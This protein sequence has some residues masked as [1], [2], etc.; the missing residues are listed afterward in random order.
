MIKPSFA[1]SDAMPTALQERA[2][3]L[4]VLMVIAPVAGTNDPPVWGKRQIESLGR[5][6]VEIAVYAF[7]NRRSLRGLLHGGRELRRKADEFQPHLIHVHFGAAQALMAVLFS[8][9]P[10]IVSF[11]GSDLLGNY[12]ASGRKTWSGVLS[13][14]LSQ[15][16]ALGSRRCIAKSEQLKQSL[17]WSKSR[18]K[19][20]V[21]PNGVD[22]R[23]FHP[24]PQAEARAVVGWLHDDPV[25][26]FMDRA[27]DWVKDPALAHAA[28]G[29]ARKK[30]RSLRLYIIENEP[31]E[32]VPLL[33]NA[34]DV[35][36]LT[37]RHEGSNN[38]LKEALACNLPVVA[39]DCGDSRERLQGIRDCFV[40]SRDAAELGLRLAQLALSRNR[41]NGR[42][43]LQGLSTDQVA[44][45]IVRCYEEALSDAPEGRRLSPRC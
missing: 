25:V 44:L 12:D 26:L 2:Q 40:C 36:L 30:V 45:R 22:G 24:I 39:T 15:L 34:A 43:H 3:S 8:D 9:R 38:T 35:L 29:E 41:S 19:C 14:V 21:I 7:H 11:C 32:R 10:V 33:Y 42:T 6:G 20:D 5:L 1:D 17:W 31:P 18:T 23:L 16:G 4:R 28:Y 27:G 13:G 37:S